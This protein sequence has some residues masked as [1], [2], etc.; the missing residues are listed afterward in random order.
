MFHV[1]D[2]NDDSNLILLQTFIVIAVT[3]LL[4][5][6]S[7][8]PFLFVSLFMLTAKVRKRS[9]KNQSDWYSLHMTIS[10]CQ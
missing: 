8:V 2:G 10:I 6:L 4:L 1:H 5:C 3:H 9:M 7:G